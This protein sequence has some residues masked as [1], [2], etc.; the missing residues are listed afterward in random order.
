MNQSKGKIL[1]SFFSYVLDTQ[2]DDSVG[3]QNYKISGSIKIARA[4]GF[5]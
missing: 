5:I 2:E 4:N 3:E 1:T